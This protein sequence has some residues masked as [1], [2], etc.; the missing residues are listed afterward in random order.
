M[1]LGAILVSSF[2]VGL[3]GA[4]MPGGLLIV[5]INE[6]IKRGLL[7]GVLA[8]TGHAL[9]ELLVVIGLSLGLGSFLG[10][11]AIVGTIA[12]IG[13]ALLAW[14]AVGTAK[15]SRVAELAITDGSGASHDDAPASNRF[16]SLTAGVLATISNPYWI[17]WWTSVGATYVAMTMDQGSAALC[18]FYIGH[19]ASDY[20]WYFLISLALVTGKRLI[21][22]RVYRG[23]LLVGSIFLGI[24]AVYFIWSGANLLIN[25]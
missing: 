15:T 23:L 18:A 2:L 19:I 13:G 11:P 14:M 20:S 21:S 17:L 10:R 25:L 6:T 3:S 22:Q 5:N 12:I 7:G 9:T 24:L 8:I 16:G 4:M 1:G